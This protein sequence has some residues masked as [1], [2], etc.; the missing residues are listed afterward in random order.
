VMM[1]LV[2]CWLVGW[3]RR[4]IMRISENW[5]RQTRHWHQTWE[6]V[7]D[8]RKPCLGKRKLS[9]G[10]ASSK[11]SCENGVGYGLLKISWPREVVANGLWQLGSW[12]SMRWPNLRVGWA[13]A[14]FSIFRW[15]WICWNMQNCL[16][17]AQ[18]IWHH[19]VPRLNRILIP[20]RYTF[21]SRHSFKN[22]T[23]DRTGEAFGL[24]F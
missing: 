12:G 21:Y 17:P 7:E 18:T 3:T 24:G 19:H 2:D 1:L 23:G 10:G 5:H 8:W 20:T 6:V 4:E 9:F 13:Q 16:I 22:R 11:G 15:W 14:L